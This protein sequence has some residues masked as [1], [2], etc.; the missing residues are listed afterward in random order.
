MSKVYE[1]DVDPDE[2]I[3][4]F[5]EESSQPMPRK[6]SEKEKTQ[7]ASPHATGAKRKERQTQIADGEEDYLD[8]FVRN[9]EHMRPLCKYLMVE[10]HPDFIKKIKRILSYES[11]A[12]CSTKAYINNVLADHFRQ[13][14]NFI[15]K[16]Q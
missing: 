14:E 4:S 10:I 7:E 13:Y 8:D 9:M 1:S 16:R 15:E 2:F 5:R 11:G 12:V 3:R 6:E